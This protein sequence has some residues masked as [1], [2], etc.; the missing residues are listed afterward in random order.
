MTEE[1]QPQEKSVR[2]SSLVLAATFGLLVLLGLT[3]FG[4]YTIGRA[5]A[6][7]PSVAGVVVE[8]L[9]VTREVVITV[10]ATPEG[11]PEQENVVVQEDDSP[12]EPTAP[13]TAAA[14]AT[15]PPEELA[16]GE[17][18][19][20]D[21]DFSTFYEV[22]DVIN[23]E[24]DGPVPNPEDVLY[25]AVNGSLETLDD[26]FT[27]FVRPEVA[28]RLREDMSGSISGIGA[29]VRENEE[30]L[31]EIV[32]PIDGQPADLAGLA[33]GDI[34]IEVDGQSVVDANFD[35][36]LLKV[37]GPEGSEVTLTVLREREDEPLEFTI[38]RT[39]FEVPIVEAEML[40]TPDA[41]V[42]YVRLTS[43]N[44]NAAESTQAEL[45]K[46]LALDP[47]G[48]IFDL[49]DNPG[50]FL[51]QSIAVAD[52]FLPEGVVLLERNNRGLSE[53]FRSDSG[54]LA[55][56]LPLAVLINAGSASASEIVAGAVKDNA[57]GTLIGETT[58]GKG[59]VQQVH[60]LS[61]GSEL[62]VTIARWYTPDNVSI[63]QAGISPDIEVE[64]P[65]DLGG[66]EDPQIQQALDFLLNNGE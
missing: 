11:Q 41:P 38:V 33:S 66:E 61:D 22:W 55:E 44:R 23:A 6:T 56:G 8:P 40:G 48:I 32:R 28:E 62:R 49:R 36:V 63:D 59:S 19:A 27:R 3:A 46:L 30:G 4:G 5:S 64:T 13:A 50:G 58:F 35:D 34:V 29:F 16:T 10:V 47:V 57:R 18:D 43:F 12:A 54:D 65:E 21:I 45:E 15:L 14:T 39:T 9:E 24:F 7:P 26:D 42:A 31:V 37:R 52:L 60:T 1:N 25:A 51:D 20:R 2:R 53:T 17:I